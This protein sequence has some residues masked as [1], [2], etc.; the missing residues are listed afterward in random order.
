MYGGSVLLDHGLL[1]GA[2]KGSLL[3]EAMDFVNVVNVTV[4]LFSY[5][6]E[7]IV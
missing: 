6:N 3:G 5:S 7:I 4:T 1:T 2:V